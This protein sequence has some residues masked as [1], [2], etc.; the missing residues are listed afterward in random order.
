MACCK[1]KGCTKDVK[2]KGLCIY[3]SNPLFLSALPPYL[4]DGSD[5]MRPSALPKGLRSSFNPMAPRYFDLNK[6]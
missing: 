2:H 6:K 3:H 1:V 5:P 4:R